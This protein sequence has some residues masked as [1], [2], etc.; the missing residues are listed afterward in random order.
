MTDPDDFLQIQY[1][2]LQQAQTDLGVAYAAAKSPIDELRSKLDK[3][4]ADWSGDAQTAH[5]EVKGDWDKAFDHMSGML[6]RAHVHVGSADDGAGL[7]GAG[8]NAGLGRGMLSMAPEAGMNPA[9]GSKERK[10]QS[11]LTES[12][13]AWSADSDDTGPVL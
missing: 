4:L 11:W 1:E 12:D 13:D 6:A 10:R 3:A 9:Q 8:A 5:T 7:V 2:T